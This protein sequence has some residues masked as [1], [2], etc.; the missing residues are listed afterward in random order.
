MNKSNYKRC[1]RN[2]YGSYDA[3]RETGLNFLERSLQSAGSSAANKYA[4]QA[5]EYLGREALDAYHGAEEGQKRFKQYKE[6]QAQPSW[7]DRQ[8]NTGLDS[9]GGA[10]AGAYK[11]AY[12]GAF[13]SDGSDD[14]V[15][16]TALD[17]KQLES[18]SSRQAPQGVQGLTYALAD[19]GQSSEQLNTEQSVGTQRNGLAVESALALAED[20]QE[21]NALQK[22]RAIENGELDIQTIA[23]VDPDSAVGG[24]EA[25][26][27]Q[28]REEMFVSPK[29][30]QR[31]VKGGLG[32]FAEFT[33][34]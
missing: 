12:N 10:I 9:I 18:A 5:G 19:I 23:P 13:G 25:R 11:E 24:I 6:E 33:K 3:D 16:K 28:F 32:L 31:A 7:V 34:G 14:L 4:T 21:L 8:L 2:T 27:E 26:L 22:V 17:Q 20:I 15:V 30:I 29:M 1:S